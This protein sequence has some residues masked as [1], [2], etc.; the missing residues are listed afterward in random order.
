[1]SIFRK[2]QAFNRRIG[3]RVPDS[4]DKDVPLSDLNSQIHLFQE[5]VVEFKEEIDDA[6]MDR[7]HNVPLSNPEGLAKEMADLVI[8]VGGIASVLG[9]DLDGV[10]KV[11]MDNN[12]K[13]VDGG[14]INSQGKLTVPAEKK[15]QLKVE[16]ERD[17]E[18]LLK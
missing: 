8:T 10:L 12:F 6:Y 5:E 14:T 3:N 17:I 13:K 16:V 4:Y 7:F 2:I 11:V 9:I 18:R 15:K 1:M